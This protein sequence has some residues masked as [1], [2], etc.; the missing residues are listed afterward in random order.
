[1][2]IA[3]P[4]SD[5]D[6]PRERNRIRARAAR[7]RRKAGEPLTARGRLRHHSYTDALYECNRADL[8]VQQ[9]REERAARVALR[10]ALP[11][12]ARGLRALCG[13]PLDPPK[14]PKLS[15]AL[16]Q[17][18][19]RL[20]ALAPPGATADVWEEIVDHFECRCAHC[21]KPASRAVPL[22]SGDPVPACPGHGTITAK[23]G[24]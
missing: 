1:M 4:P 23:A 24:A 17:R 8:L 2:R 15:R 9:A 12:V 21:G 7:L 6:T 22:P 11:S 20:L 5:E 13:L 19:R 14:P 18:R 3:R 16:E 10:K